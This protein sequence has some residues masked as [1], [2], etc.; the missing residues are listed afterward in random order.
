MSTDTKIIDTNKNNRQEFKDKLDFYRNCFTWQNFLGNFCWDEGEEKFPKDLL[1][2]FRKAD[3][4]FTRYLMKISGL[5][6]LLTDDEFEK[7]HTYLKSETTN[8][9]I[10]RATSQNICDDHSIVF[11]HIVHFLVTI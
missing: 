7:F 9:D 5:V 8:V 4:T 10:E 3:S 6:D 2:K 11:H 1:E